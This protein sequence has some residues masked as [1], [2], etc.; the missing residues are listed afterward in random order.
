[1]TAMLATV[2]QVRALH[3]STLKPSEGRKSVHELCGSLLPKR[4]FNG[5]FDGLSRSQEEGL[6]YFPAQFGHP[7]AITGTVA[8]VRGQSA[9]LRDYFRSVSDD[10]ILRNAFFVSVSFHYSAQLTLS[11]SR[12]YRF[13]LREPVFRTC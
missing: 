10:Q 2:V 6:V 12:P 7:P 8:N 1:M 11:W 3:R 4:P 5:T 13:S 9:T